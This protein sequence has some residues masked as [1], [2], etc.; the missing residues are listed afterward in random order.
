MPTPTP[1][2]ARRAG[3][4]RDARAAKPAVVNVQRMRSA[5]PPDPSGAIEVHLFDGTRQPA[6]G[7]E[8]LVRLINGRQQS[9]YQGVHPGPTIRFTGLRV[10]D[11]LDD[12]FLVSVA[13]DG[14]A[15]TGFTP[16]VI[17]S[18]EITRVDLMLIPK[19]NRFD[20][21]DASWT[22]LSNTHPDL[23]AF[24]SSGAPGAAAARA[25]YEALMTDQPR[26]LAGLLNIWTAME[27]IFLGDGSPVD[28]LKQLDWNTQPPAPDRFYCYA[29]PNLVT[30]VVQA[31]SKGVFD[32]EANP[33]AFHHGATRSYKQV[34]FGE[35]N[36]Q[37]T[38]HENDTQTIDGM[39]CVLVEPDIDYYKDLLA[40]GLL[41]VL[42]NQITAPEQV[43]VL[44]WIAGQQAGIPAFD[45]PYAIVAAPKRATP[46]A[47]RKPKRKTS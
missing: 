24:L 9:V 1:R 11:N 34:Q 42:P 16:V 29:D 4:R 8:A 6:V 17:R 26:A 37:L 12:R 3:L 27:G 30:E 44:R 39:S 14:C 28:Y 41:E 21:T 45:P 20:F 40:H 7:V 47:R 22:A 2:R 25:R 32:R 10:A 36:V 35:A 31:A 23:V 18:G 5:P 15:M 38:F 43:Y 33:Q 46:A 13:V 19:S